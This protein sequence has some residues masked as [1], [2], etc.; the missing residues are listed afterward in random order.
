MATESFDHPFLNKIRTLGLLF[1]A[2]FLVLTVIGAISNPQQ[3]YQSYIIGYV[4]WL[5]IS[6][7]CL[8]LLMLHHLISGRWGFVIRRLLESGARTL[9]LMVILFI[10]IIFGMHNLYEWTH[11]DVVANDPILKFKSPYLNE[12]GFISRAVFYFVLWIGMTW[13]LTKWSRTQDETGEPGLKSK[14]INLSGP[15]IPVL[16]LSVTFASTDWVM[17]LEPH[18]FSTIFGFIFVVGQALAAMAM[19]IIW[20][21]NLSDADA[22]SEIEASKYLS[23]LGTLMFA[24]TV[25]WSYVS[26]SQFLIIWSANLAE[27]APWYIKRGQGG[28]DIMAV[29]LILFHFALPFF[30]LLQR[31]IKRRAALLLAIAV[32]MLVMRYVDLYWYIAPSF[33]HGGPVG[34]HPHFLDL[35]IPLSIGGFWL[36]YF[37]MQLKGAALVPLHD[38]RMAETFAG[39]GH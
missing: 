1:G 23:D 13:L 3:F 14:M 22:F 20:V 25:L 38:P 7:G 21:V 18:W 16:I 39:E 12:T 6:L 8:S 4:Y 2:L 17:S 26:F 10:P 32:L 27:E 9:P 36:A 15:G 37:A 35:T 29:A 19:C 11:A 30:L 34:F 24:F 33:S 5:C 31:A 28:W